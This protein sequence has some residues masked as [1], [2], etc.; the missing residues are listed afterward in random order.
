MNELRRLARLELQLAGCSPTVTRP[1][2]PAPLK[3]KKKKR[4]AEKAY[5]TWLSCPK[6]YDIALEFNYL[7]EIGKTFRGDARKMEVSLT[8]F[9]RVCSFAYGFNFRC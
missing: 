6:G 7:D 2:R 3:K 8:Q 5:R 1:K 4:M 9:R